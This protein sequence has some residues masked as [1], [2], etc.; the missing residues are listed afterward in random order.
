LKDKTIN[1]SLSI[2][3]DLLYRRFGPRHWWPGDTRLEVIIG[4]ILTQNTSWVNVEKAIKNLKKAKALSV[5]KLY[6]IPEKKL[7][8]LIRPSGYYNVKADRIKNFL[9]FLKAYY[10]GS[11]SRMFMEDLYRL[12]ENLLAVKG[13]GRE[14]ADSILLY[15]GNKPIFVVDAY[16][17]RMFSRHGFIDEDAEYGEIQSLFMNNLPE[18]AGLFNEF[19]ALIVELGKSICKS[20]Q[21][22]CK[23]CPIRGVQ[24][25]QNARRSKETGR[26]KESAGNIRK[27]H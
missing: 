4:A 1:R 5:S 27:T 16:T 17:K 6:S 15:A 18:N 2:I 22:L 11:I 3:Y 24:R 9:R 7:A 20:K 21:P 12:R 14:T 10:A 19:H 23:T 26:N 8:R 25:R 13:I